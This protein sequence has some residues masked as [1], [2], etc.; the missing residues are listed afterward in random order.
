MIRVGVL[1]ILF[2]AGLALAWQIS[3]TLLMLFA[4]F[5]L[6]AVIDAAV[7]GLR[8][9][10]PIGRGWLLLI[11]VALALVLLGALAVVGGY[12]IWRQLEDLWAVLVEGADGLLDSLEQ[13]GLPLGGVLQDERGILDWIP[14]PQTIFGQ[15]GTA[16]G[17]T[18]GLASDALIVALL[19]VFLA[20][21]PA[22]YREGVLTLVPTE[23]RARLRE[24]LNVTGTT[25]KWWLVGQLAMMVL[26]GT[27]V[28]ILLLVAGVPYA[29]LLGLVTGLLNFIPFL[30]PIL[31]GIP[32]L[33]ALIPEGWGTLAW[34]MAV[35]LV[36]QWIEG[37][38]INPFV[39]QKVV[40]IAPALGLS[41]LAI[42]AALFGGLGV[43]L[44]I[45]LLA[46]LRVLVLELYVKDVL[47][48][49]SQ[50]I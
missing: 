27:L 33:L 31:A 32:L 38:L 7:S 36:I 49:R 34:V 30:G 45:P 2:G 23:R 20:I 1:V 9:V 43:A 10:L 17:M 18:M 40:H 14:D 35:F 11:V 22:S 47:G 25:L 15:A 16:F 24:V 41:F 46:V 48:D 26:V 44:A 13:W 4:G 8:H 37:Y 19:G 28:T 50:T 3:G 42:M 5:L 12:N 29:V 39:Q 6:A 21:D